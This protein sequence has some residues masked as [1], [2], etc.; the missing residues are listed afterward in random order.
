VSKVFTSF[1]VSKSPEATKE[2]LKYIKYGV[3][4]LQM[5]NPEARYVVLTDRA[6]APELEQHVEVAVT[7]PARETS[8]MMAGIQAQAAYTKKSTDELTIHAAPDC[9]V[10][11]SLSGVWC[12][13]THGVAITY[14]RPPEPIN[15]VAYIRDHELAY[16]F[17]K[18]AE[19]KLETVRGHKI[20]DWGGDQWAWYACLPEPW[21]RLPPDQGF[22]GMPE[23]AVKMVKA[24]VTADK[25][26]KIYLY[27]CTSHNH[28]VRVTGGPKRL[29][30]NAFMLHF[31]GPRKQHMAE[32]LYE[33]IPYWMNIDKGLIERDE[34]YED[35]ASR[36]QRLLGRKAAKSA[37]P[38]GPRDSQ[39]DRLEEREGA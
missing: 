18:Q 19:E 29:T 36:I 25:D 20:F 3:K 15:N 22:H 39:S 10:A 11:R 17:L 26:R 30:R 32:Y 23:A 7:A 21:E 5:T 35:R 16:W 34:D 28:F 2:Y 27:S 37:K 24:K 9:M 1:F 14:R 33:H 13:P 6:T 31:K 8:M 38:D 4:A 12:H